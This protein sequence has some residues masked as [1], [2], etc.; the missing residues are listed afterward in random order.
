MTMEMNT[1]S[2]LFFIRRTKLRSNGEAPIYLRVTTNGDRLELA[3]A[4]SIN[5]DDFV[6]C[7]FFISF[8]I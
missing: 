1:F 6:F 4:R 3:T 5:P 8:I 2:V 7:I